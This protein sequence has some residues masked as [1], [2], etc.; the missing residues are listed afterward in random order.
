MMEWLMPSFANCDFTFVYLTSSDQITVIIV[1]FVLNSTFCVIYS[2]LIASFWAV[3]LSF[4][5][6]CSMNYMLEGC[7]HVKSRV[8]DE[9]MYLRSLKI[10]YRNL[11]SEIENTKEYFFFKK[12]V[13]FKPFNSQSFS[14]LSNKIGAK[15]SIKGRK[16]NIFETI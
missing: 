7:L 16:H 13:C 10:V 3:Q 2:I 6:S 4:S 1:I 9:T 14:P 5:V 15:D 11:M 12:M 8:S